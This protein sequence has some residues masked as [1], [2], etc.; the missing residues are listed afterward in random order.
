M[1]KNSMN[2]WTWQ[3]N[4]GYEPNW[5]KWAVLLFGLTALTIIWMFKK[6]INRHY[7]SGR[8]ILFFKTKE[9]Y[10]Q[11][12]GIV[13]LTLYIIRW[14][15]FIATGY[16]M[17]WENLNLHLCR[18]IGLYI[19]L[20]MSFRRFELV[21][22]VAYLAIVGFLFGMIFAGA[23]SNFINNSN[24]AG[25]FTD[26][27]DMNGGN[28][29]IA[30]GK[31]LDSNNKAI[32]QVIQIST[33]DTHNITILE[34][35]FMRHGYT[36]YHVGMDNMHFY[37]SYAIHLSILLFP[38]YIMISFD[39][40]LSVVQYH[41]FNI[42]GILFLLFVWLLNAGLGNISDIRWR[43]NFWYVGMDANNDMKAALGWLSAWPQNF[44]SYA[45]I[46]LIIPSLMHLIYVTQDKLTFFEDGKFIQKSKSIMYVEAKKEYKRG[47]K[48]IFVE[49]LIGKTK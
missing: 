32:T 35:I 40:K 9:S 20:V 45:I 11:T 38:I 12:V 13:S 22:Y 42:Y 39:Y 4:E 46:S 47:F 37:E 6:K 18:I 25:Q 23:E 1:T 15:I 43:P 8:K 28:I 34:R 30:K 36:H 19:F 24:N 16:P 48:S 26:Y 27:T 3:G 49:A 31:L 7:N 33:G 41:R 17:H 2:F 10:F 21:K 29:H 5:I 44:F 14:I